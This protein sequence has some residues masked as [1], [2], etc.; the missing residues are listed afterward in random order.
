MKN[1]KIKGLTLWTD[2]LDDP[3]DEKIENLRTLLKRW[4]EG[5][6]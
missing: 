1:T 4:Q 3:L 6:K 2:P 5:M